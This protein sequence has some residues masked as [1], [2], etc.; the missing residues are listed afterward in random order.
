MVFSLPSAQKRPVFYMDFRVI[1][2]LILYANQKYQKMK[3]YS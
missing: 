3:G 1:S 2:V